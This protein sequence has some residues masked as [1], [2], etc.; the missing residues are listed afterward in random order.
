MD[1]LKIYVGNVNSIK[2]GDDMF[3]RALVMTIENL[4][5]KKLGALE[6]IMKQVYH[7]YIRQS[8]GPK[9]LAELLNYN[10]INEK[11]HAEFMTKGIDA[12]KR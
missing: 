8:C 5:G 10:N 7:S 6:A 12:F 1:L 11:N 3:E 2:L 9:L 4:T